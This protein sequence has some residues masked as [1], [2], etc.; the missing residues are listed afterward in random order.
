MLET[1]PTE[2][3]LFLCGGRHLLTERSARHLDDALAQ[4]ECERSA[5]LEA[6][7][8]KE[9]DLPPANLGMRVVHVLVVAGL[10]RLGLV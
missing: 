5:P 7:A 3:H 1:D 9:L 10:G 4:R 8:S 2:A 6:G